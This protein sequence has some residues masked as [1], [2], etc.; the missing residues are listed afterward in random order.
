MKI[1]A[2]YLGVCIALLPVLLLRDF[3]PSN[4]L[5]YL[6]IAEESLRS[7]RWVAFTY[8]GMPYAD[9]PPLY[10]WIIRLGYGLF[11][12]HQMSFLSLFSLLPALV[13]AYT[14]DRWAGPEMDRAG[15]G[16]GPESYRLTA[17]WLLL[18]C[19]LFLG[20]A[21]FLRMDMLMSMFI[22][23]SLRRFYRLWK[24]EGNRWINEL[25]FPIYLFLGVFSKGPMGIL[26]PL[27][28]T[29]VFLLWSRR[30]RS[31]GTFWGWK[32]WGVFLLGC[33]LW[34]GWVYKEGGGKYLSNL[35]FHQT[36]DRA[37]DSFHHKRPFYYYFLSL[38]YSAFPWSLLL[39]GVT[40]VTFWKKQV[41]S[42]LARFFFSVFLATFGLLSLIS[43]KLVV[44]LV[45]VFPFWVYGV[46]LQLSS[47]WRWNRGVALAIAFPAV[48][49]SATLPLLIWLGHQ[50]ATG[51]LNHGLLYTAGGILALT[52]IGSLYLLYGR[53]QLSRAIRLLAIGLLGAIFTGGWEMPVINRQIGYGE[54]CREARKAARQ[55]GSTEYGVWNIRR[56]EAMDVYLGQGVRK[57]SWEE[58]ISGRLKGTVL[59]L[60][61][62]EW[63]AWEGKIPAKESY[64]VGPY[65]IV[66]L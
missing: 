36:F 66:V 34:W 32:T 62:P 5:R 2:V 39:I 21:V 4:E 47:R 59:M 31:F 12:N 9:K 58:V 24:E 16:V 57:V 7:G 63:K 29:L 18:S 33:L 17:Q 26:I 10:F 1:K 15:R 11:G 30:L 54:L 40:V 20:L 46:A 55:N 50:K 27:A 14:M 60:P 28:G 64:D 48:V 23:L 52:G 13:I 49:Y 53:K 44:Y 3:S 6:S 25:L 22:V 61:A 8:Q 65:S 19:G 38:W 51:W 43:S 35:L 56:P 42:E 45:P 41:S 37:V